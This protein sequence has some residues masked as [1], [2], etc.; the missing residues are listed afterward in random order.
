MSFAKVFAGVSHRLACTAFSAR[1]YVRTSAPLPI[2][3]LQCTLGHLPS[4]LL[5]AIDLKLGPGHVPTR[6]ESDQQ[7]QASICFHDEGR[8]PA[9]AA[10]DAAAEADHVAFHHH[11][12][13]LHDSSAIFSTFS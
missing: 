7:Q 3:F 13:A 5:N 10:A 9:Y 1:G 12:A 8:H 2:R 4:L 6:L 11:Q